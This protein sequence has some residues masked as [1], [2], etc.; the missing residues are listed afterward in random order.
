MRIIWA[1]EDHIRPETLLHNES[2]HKSQSMERFS[3]VRAHED[4]SIE[5]CPAMALRLCV[6]V[7]VGSQGVFCQVEGHAASLAANHMVVDLFLYMT[8]EPIV[9]EITQ[10]M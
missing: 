8:I 3:H 5:A 10:V 2:P 6:R 1:F 4:V 7:E 9:E